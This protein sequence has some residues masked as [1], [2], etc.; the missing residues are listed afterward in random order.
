MG[1]SRT[2]SVSWHVPDTMSTETKVPKDTVNLERKPKY[3]ES[4][5]VEEDTD[6]PNQENPKELNQSVFINNGNGVQIGI[7]YGTIDLSHRKED[8]D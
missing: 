3:A 6:A 8:K 7:N 4:E 2:V 1:K 5:V